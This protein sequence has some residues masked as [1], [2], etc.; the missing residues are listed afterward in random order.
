MSGR[1]QKRNDSWLI[2]TFGD[3]LQDYSLRF[4]NSTAFRLLYID[5][6]C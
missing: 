1:K 6:A 2:E 4:T 3:I 5:R